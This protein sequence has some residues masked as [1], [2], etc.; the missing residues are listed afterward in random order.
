MSIK[1]EFNHIFDSFN[2][3]TNYSSTSVLILNW[4]DKYRESIKSKDA[5]KDISTRIGDPTEELQ[6]I[7]DDFLYGVKYKALRNEF[8]RK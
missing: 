5:I 2:K 8:Y 3:T 6:D 4:I 1:K 7:I